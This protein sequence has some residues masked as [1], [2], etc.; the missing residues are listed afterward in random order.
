MKSHLQQT[1]TS[2]SSQPTETKAHWEK[3]VK[4]VMPAISIPMYD[5]TAIPDAGLLTF[6]DPVEGKS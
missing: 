6:P 1:E 2:P 4:E 5:S 3:T